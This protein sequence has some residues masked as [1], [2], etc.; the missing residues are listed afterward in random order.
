MIGYKLVSQRKNGTIGPLFINKKL[1]IKIGEWME[2]E[3][4]LTKGFKFRPGWHVMSE[5]KAPHLSTKGRVWVKVECQGYTFEKRPDS[6]GGL[7]YLA[8]RMRVLEIL[9]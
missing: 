4:H 2:A 6:Q 8:N 7:W 1:V 3:P 5:Q 9:K